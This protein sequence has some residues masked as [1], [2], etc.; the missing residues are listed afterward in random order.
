MLSMHHLRHISDISTVSVWSHKWC[1]HCHLHLLQA[2][3]DKVVQT[4]SSPSDP[5]SRNHMA[6]YKEIIRNFWRVL[7]SDLPTCKFQALVLG[8]LGLRCVLDSSVGVKKTG[9]QSGGGP[10]GP[11]CT[12]AFF[13]S[14][15]PELAL[16]SACMEKP[17]EPQQVRGE[18]ELEPGRVPQQRGKQ[19]LLEGRWAQPWWALRN[20]RASGGGTVAI[21]VQ[22]SGRVRQEA[23]CIG[24]G[25]NRKW[26]RGF[27]MV[28]W[29]MGFLVCS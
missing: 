15:V 18:R 22:I 7:V 12:S 13:E 19:G 25:T 17:G 3:E 24:P 6:L 1:P 14:R 10:F 5:T 4:Q 11:V 29:E 26:G 28:E 23:G 9:T 21:G 20:I 8:M 16:G 27:R 2:R